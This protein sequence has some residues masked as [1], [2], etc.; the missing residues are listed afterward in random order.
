MPP[1]SDAVAPEAGPPQGLCPCGRLCVPVDRMRFLPRV[2][3]SSYSKSYVAA[4]LALL[5]AVCATM[6][7]LSVLSLA[8]SA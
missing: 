6:A 5:R 3:S 8:R 4:P 7:T 1:S 2:L